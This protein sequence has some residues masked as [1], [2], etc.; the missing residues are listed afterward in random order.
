MESIKEIF[1]IGNG[2]SSSHTIGPRKAAIMF[3]ERYPEVSDYRVTLY[4]SLAATGVGHLTDKAI[5]NELT[6]DKTELVFRPEIELDYH[7]N[8]MKFEALNDEGDTQGEWTV[9]SVGGGQ[10]YDGKLKEEVKEIYDLTTMTDILRWCKQYGNQFWEFV[11]SREDSDI[12]DYLETV[13]RVMEDS[14]RRG[15]DEEGTI[16]GGL[17]LSR[18]ASSYYAKA[19]GYRSSLKRRSLTFAYALAVAEENASGGLIVTAP[20]CGSS[21]VLPAVL[22]M[23]RHDFEFSKKKIL[24][25]LATAGIIGNIVKTNASISGAKVGCQGEVGTACAMASGA[26]AQ[27][28]GGTVSQIEY[29]SEMGLEHHLGLTCDPIGGLVQVPCIER[30][31]FGATRALDSS[32]YAIL[33]DGSHLVSFDKIV[34]TMNQTGHD[35]PSIYKE[36]S[37]GG[38]AIDL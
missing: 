24:R 15:I 2:P 22:Y 36:T 9:Y 18:K 17:N 25:A 3:R 1:K 38:L 12:W 16:P 20:T 21:G 32:T 34:K 11:Q 8:G 33:S 27:V 5:Y 4:G 26:A 23:L 37:L 7:P 13:W 31:A 30:N 19:K 10:L 14:V 28:F 35:L 29:A 6:K